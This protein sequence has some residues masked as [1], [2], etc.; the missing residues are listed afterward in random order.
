MRKYFFTILIAYIAGIA[1]IGV[2][3][4]L[5]MLIFVLVLM[6][7]AVFHLC[8]F[9]KN[10]LTAAAVLAFGAGVI[11]FYVHQGL[12]AMP[13]EDSAAKTQ[14]IVCQI[15]DV[16]VLE[17]G[18]V[19]YEARL[20]KED[21]GKTRGKLRLYVKDYENTKPFAYGDTVLVKAAQIALPDSEKQAAA[22]RRY[23]IYAQVNTNALLLSRAEEQAFVN[24]FVKSVLQVKVRA[25]DAIET[26]LPGQVAA[27]VKAILL[28]DKNS[29]SEEVKNDFSRSG[30]SHMLAVSG[31]HLSLFILYAGIFLSGIT[32][33]KR[34][35]LVPLI[36]CLLCVAASVM[37][38]FGYPV[39]RAAIMMI[40]MNVGTMLGRERAPVNSLAIAAAVIL[41][42]N[43]Y[44][45]FDVS[46]QLSFVSTLGIVL[47]AA[48]MSSWMLKKSRFK[49]KRL[50]EMASVTICA[51]AAT[52]PI[53][54]FVFNQIS[55]LAIVANILAS[56]VMS[57]LLGLSV[58]FLA[59]ALL[60]PKFVALFSGCVYLCARLFLFIASFVANIPFASI[61]VSGRQALLDLLLLGSIALCI[62]TVFQSKKKWERAAGLTLACVVAVV[63]V[64]VNLPDGT[65]KVTFLDV[66][67]GDCTIVKTPEGN[68]ILIDG[69]GI[70][71][72]DYDV[73]GKV[74]MPYLLKNGIKSLDCAVVSHYHYDH[75]GGI[76]SLL[77]KM[78]VKTLVM[79]DTIN[80][81][82]FEVRDMLS[83]LAE[84]NGTKVYYFSRGDSY[85]T[86]DGVE[87]QTLSPVKDRWY[88]QNNQSLVMKLT[89][90]DI[91]F[92][93][94]GDLES[95]A[96]RAILS[97][98]LQS[99]VLKVGHHG[100]S[101]S[102]GEQFLKTVN[103]AVAVISA[104][105]DNSYGHPHAATLDALNSLQIDYYRTDQ[106]GTVTITV[107]KSGIASIRTER[108][109]KNEGYQGKRAAGKQSAAVFVLWRRGIFEGVLRC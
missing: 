81:D 15:V 86:P 90:R 88:S 50:F 97:G 60:F 62:L 53:T 26:Y 42:Q 21:G 13:F 108:G 37:T 52:F 33:R 109:A 107:D 100:S 61:V 27:V 64:F 74:V 93:F 35:F 32:G 77:E 99:T 102:S 63:L 71:G 55:L 18:T 22:W 30:L 75:Y 105:K 19:I 49:C 24:P 4:N 51:Q 78:E 8:L 36:N 79:P 29:L 92:L 83:D 12:L 85:K 98:E 43:P 58:L 91:S 28:G 56:P 3:T 70:E 95:D 76:A 5:N 14:D 17:E 80:L 23:G 54:V 103:P 46:F 68:S 31:L 101:T 1:A 89:Y 57:L 11:V 2:Y 25:A 69:G 47:F 41:L 82:D 45:V 6:G 34:R 104:G 40:L 65:L 106:N 94:T 73:G 10:R 84:K 59:V 9:R 20:I 67:Q 16:P 44:A 38:G 72:S 96:E 7:A 39:I 66:G 48:P 87:I